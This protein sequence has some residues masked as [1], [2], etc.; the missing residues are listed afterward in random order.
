MDQTFLFITSLRF[1][2]EM[3]SLSLLFNKLAGFYGILALVTGYSLSFLQLS[4]YIYS[5]AALVLL[6]YLMSHIQKASPLEMVALAW[7]YLIDTLLNG[8]Y[9]SFFAISW[10]LTLSAA[11]VEKEAS[12][13]G[14]GTMNDTAGFTDPVAGSAADIDGAVPAADG[15]P[16]LANGAAFTESVPSIL[17]IVLFNIVRIYFSIILFSYARQALKGYIAT[18]ASN[19]QHLHMDGLVDEL[20]GPFSEGSPL[21][22]G[23]KGKLGRAMTNVGSEWWLGG[24]KEDEEWAR[25]QRGKFERVQK[26]LPGTIA[27]EQRARS[28]TGPPPMR[29]NTHLRGQSLAS[30]GGR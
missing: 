6:C 22:G 23:W 29:I 25:E 14:A 20:D 15:T 7:F 9:T 8:A 4:M 5:L 1:G 17:L 21:G 2:A 11:A 3:I 19:R 12:A 16:S 26:E 24:T 13:P 27:R 30:N 28:G 18:K 10:F